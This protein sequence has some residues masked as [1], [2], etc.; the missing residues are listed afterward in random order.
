M[1]LKAFISMVMDLHL[2]LQPWKKGGWEVHVHR[3][4]PGFISEAFYG[5]FLVDYKGLWTT[6]YWG[7]VLLVYAFSKS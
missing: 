5:G 6:D 7:F 1:L 2:C 3:K 4:S